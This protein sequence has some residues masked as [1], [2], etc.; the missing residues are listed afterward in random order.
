[1]IYS[2]MI[3]MSFFFCTIAFVAISCNNKKCYEVLDYKDLP[4]GSSVFSVYTPD[5]NWIEMEKYAIEL[6]KNK[7]INSGVCFYNYKDSLFK[8]KD[9]G[10]FK[11]GA[12]DKIIAIYNLNPNTN[13]LEFHKTKNRK[14]LKFFI[15]KCLYAE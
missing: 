3:K 9:N 1:M 7:S 6:L 10:A 4:N 12:P 13:K 15:K 2:I 14:N 5:T 11:T 8:F